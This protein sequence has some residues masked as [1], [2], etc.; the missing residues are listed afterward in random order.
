VWTIAGVVGAAVAIVL[1]VRF[2]H[3]RPRSLTIQGAVI[4]KDEDSRK[5]SP[6][7]DADIIAS[8]GVTSTSTQSD[9]S[10]Y[11]KIIFPEAVWPGQT[12]NLT[13]SHVN[14]QSLELKLPTGL[15]LASREL[16]VA[17]MTPTPQASARSIDHP[18]SVVSNIVVRYTVNT[19]SDQNVGS[20]VKTFQVVNKANVPCN[21]R[22]PCS[23]DG[24]WKAASGSV[25]LDAGPGSEFRNARASCIAGPCPFTRLD[26]S[27]FVNGGRTITASALDWSDTATF[28][29]EA[30]VFRTGMASRVRLLYPVLFGQALHFTLPPTEEGVT[31]E[32]DINGTPMVFPLGPELYLSWATCTARNNTEPEKTTVYRCELKP[33]YRF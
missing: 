17:A 33:D 25:S 3:W 16:Y 28:L 11:F 24:I 5:E 4:R 22:P 7:S 21:G 9:A 18:V 6:I 10:G 20:A 29:L 26:S 31:I 1:V 12:L 30:E 19:E 23:P 2:H 15:R 8:D 32:A 13:F 27:G 14:Y